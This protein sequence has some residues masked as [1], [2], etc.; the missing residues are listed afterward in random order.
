MT[1]HRYNKGIAYYIAARTGDDYLHHLY[2][3]ALQK[4]GIAIVAGSRGEGISITKR[5]DHIFLMNFSDKA[6][7][8][9]LTVRIILL[10]L[11]NV[12]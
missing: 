5:G 2:N 9:V 6:G 7:T 1:L 4:A 3:E 11:M 10:S 12:K 8:T